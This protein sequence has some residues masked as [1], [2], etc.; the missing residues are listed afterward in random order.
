[1]MRRFPFLRV[2]K[3]T[4]HNPS[5]PNDDLTYAGYLQIGPSGGS[6]KLRRRRGVPLPL[7]T[8]SCHEKS[9]RTTA[10]ATAT[11]APHQYS[12]M[13][14]TRTPIFHERGRGGAVLLFSLT[15]ART[16]RIVTLPNMSR[17]KLLRHCS[18][19]SITTRLLP[20]SK[21]RT[22]TKGRTSPMFV[23]IDS[24]R[25]FGS[26]FLV[27]RTRRTVRLAKVNSSRRGSMI[28]RRSL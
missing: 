21:T 9:L 26:Q 5:G 7:G 4:S 27:T 12:T 22:L 23:R 6:I 10:S 19:T 8:P 24:L 28:V 14:P 18:S 20:T 17:G 25:Q 3:E 1:M 11:V 16:A 15:R 2:A 13:R